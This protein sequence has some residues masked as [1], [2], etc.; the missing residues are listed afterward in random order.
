LLASKLLPLHHHVDYYYYACVVHSIV[1]MRNIHHWETDVQ[2]G[3]KLTME[4][5]FITIGFTMLFRL[6]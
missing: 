2:S 4:V 6:H 5:T 3:S 1:Y